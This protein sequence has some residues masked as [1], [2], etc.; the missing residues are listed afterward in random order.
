[1][2]VRAQSVYNLLNKK[3]RLLPFTGV[4]HDA[5]SEPSAMGIWFVYGDSAS[6]KTS[7]AYQLAKYFEKRIKKS[8]AYISFEEAG[9]HTM[10]EAAIRAGWKV[11]GSRIRVVDPVSVEELDR[12]LEKHKSPEVIIVDTLQ[13]WQK[14]YSVKADGLIRLMEKYRNKLFVYLSHVKKGEPDGSLAVTVMREAGLKI[15][16]EGFRAF[17]KGRYFGTKEYYSIW[18]EKEKTIWL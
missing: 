6:G 9:S 13:R 16:V 7:F 18:A 4:W 10:Q 1:M 17:S 11:K 3:H 14:T 15:F 2:A 5:F 8:V 12:W